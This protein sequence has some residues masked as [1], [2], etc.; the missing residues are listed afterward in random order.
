MLQVT[1]KEAS[2]KGLKS[3]IVLLKTFSKLLSHNWS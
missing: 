3:I 1:A 2:D